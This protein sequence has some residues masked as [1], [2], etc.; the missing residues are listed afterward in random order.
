MDTVRQACPQCRSTL[1]LPASAVGRMARCPACQHTFRVEATFANAPFTQGLPSDTLPNPANSPV[2]PGPPN[3]SGQSPWVNAGGS[4]NPYDTSQPAISNNPY[5]MT[6]GMAVAAAAAPVGKGDIVIRRA[7]VDRITS[8]ATALFAARWQPLVLAGLIV[9]AFSFGLGIIAAVVGAVAEIQDATAAVLTG[10]A[11]QILIGF[12][13][14]YFNMGMIRVALSVARGEHASPTQVFAPPTVVLRIIVPLFLLT[15]IAASSQFGRFAIQNPGDMQ[16]V[17]VMLGAAAVVGLLQM[18]VLWLIWPMFFL[19]ADDRSGGFQA[20]STGFRISSA[21]LLNGF[22]LGIL[23]MLLGV[24]GVVTCGL[25]VL[26]TQPILMLVATIAYLEMT[27]QPVQDPN[28][29]P[30]I[31]PNYSYSPN[32]F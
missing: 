9:L 3:P 17:V 31:S 27:S 21:N 13:S 29:S 30:A 8:L 23:A 10:F 26:I 20:L 4:S 5:A 16:G 12:V 25:G 1:E 19:A 24:L 32:K 11:T 2:V 6:S 22:L 15:L 28:A 14:Y 7:S 18:L